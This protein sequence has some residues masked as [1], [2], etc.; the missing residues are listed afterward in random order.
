MSLRQELLTRTSFWAPANSAFTSLSNG[1]T[2]F[3]HKR[4]THKTD[5]ACL[6][7]FTRLTLLRRILLSA[8]AA[9]SSFSG[10]WKETRRQHATSTKRCYTA[11]ASCTGDPGSGSNNPSKSRSASASAACQNKLRNN[12]YYIFDLSC[13]HDAGGGATL[14]SFHGGA[15]A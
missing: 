10:S 9:A 8:S 14:V 3:H 6:M 1:V 15:C 4:T 13:P 7:S 11:H 12:L 5:P 2:R